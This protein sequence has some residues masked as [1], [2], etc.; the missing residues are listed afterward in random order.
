MHIPKAHRGSGEVGGAEAAA[1][2]EELDNRQAM[3][4]AERGD[5]ERVELVLHLPA[6]RVCGPLGWA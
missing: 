4:D 3:L 5:H 1:A 2:A 6:C